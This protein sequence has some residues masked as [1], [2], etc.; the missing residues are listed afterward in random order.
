MT[1]TDFAAALQA[2][3]QAQDFAATP[4]TW[5][6]G[7]PVGPHPSIDLAVAAFPPGRAPLWANVLFSREHPQGVVADI[8]PPAGPVLNIRYD[9]DLRDRQLDSPLWL[10]DADWSHFELQPLAAASIEPATRFV[11]TYPASLL[12][13]MLAVAPGTGSVAPPKLR[14]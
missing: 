8:A 4:D 13:L 12:K 5:Q 2:A 14:D 3:V 7:A 10:P 6:S 1:P 9:K 11:A